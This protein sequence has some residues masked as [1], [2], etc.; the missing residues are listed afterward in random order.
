MHYIFSELPPFRAR[1]TGGFVL[2]STLWVLTVLTIAIGFFA[3]WTQRAVQISIEAQT[4]IQAQRDMQSTQASLLYLLA[5]QR[6][7]YAGMTVTPPNPDAAPLDEDTLP[8]LVGEEITLDDQVYAGQGKVRFAIQDENGLLNINAN[9]RFLL[10]RLL[11]VLG[12]PNEAQWALLAKVRDYI[13]LDD[14]HRLNG[15]ESAHYKEVSLLPPTNR[16]LRSPL[17]TKRVFDWERRL[18]PEQF[19]LLHQFTTVA[20]AGGFGINFNTAPAQVLRVVEGMNAE[21]VAKLVAFRRRTPLTHHTMLF[22]V[23]QKRLPIDEDTFTPYY[24][25]SV[26]LRIS[27]WHENSA[28]MRQLYLKLTPYSDQ[29]KPWK[30]N[31]ILEMPVYSG[32]Q[33][34]SPLQVAHLIFGNP[35]P[36]LAK[37]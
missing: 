36:E 18:Q 3:L 10:R 29:A 24:F 31:R 26:Y 2:V 23:L 30:F 34:Q 37:P 16:Y 35:P 4:D 27:L 8:P 9:D 19:S 5:T 17:E 7:T 15:A 12:V 14:L 20:A 32:Y 21:N 33:Q 11:G 22:R 6:F 1:K 28:W 13:D 25:P